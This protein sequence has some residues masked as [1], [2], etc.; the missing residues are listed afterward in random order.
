MADHDKPECAAC[1]ACHDHDGDGKV[2]HRPRTLSLTLAPT[3]TLT[4]TLTL[5]PTF[6]LTLTRTLTP[7]FTLTL[8]RTLAPTFTLTLTL[9]PKPN[10]D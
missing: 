6:T 4:L 7:T 3:F 9:D 1:A 5:A 10:P 2:D 8:T